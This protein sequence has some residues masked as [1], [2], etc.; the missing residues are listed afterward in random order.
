MVL[1]QVKKKRNIWILGAFIIIFFNFFLLRFHSCAPL[2]SFS[3]TCNWKIEKYVVNYSYD[4]QNIAPVCIQTSVKRRKKGSVTQY[5]HQQS[6]VSF[7]AFFLF[8]LF[9][10][11]HW[12]SKCYLRF[13][14]GEFLI[15]AEW[16]F[17]SG[18]KLNSANEKFDWNH[19]K[20]RKKNRCKIFRIKTMELNYLIGLFELLHSQY[21]AYLRN[22]FMYQFAADLTLYALR[23]HKYI[24]SG[25]HTFCQYYRWQLPIFQLFFRSECS[26]IGFHLISCFQ[27]LQWRAI[28]QL[29]SVV[30]VRRSMNTEVVIPLYTYISNDFLLMKIFGSRILVFLKILRIVTNN[31]R[32]NK[33]FSSL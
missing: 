26:T 15:Y 18:K 10:V 16:N 23:V 8:L 33:F 19:F 5:H 11:F 6:T 32:W 31:N 1:L 22:N 2:S 27:W 28:G 30:A 12:W 24:I 9:S 21:C 13:S 4:E 14:F 3:I 17:P 25:R 7:H 20:S 29:M